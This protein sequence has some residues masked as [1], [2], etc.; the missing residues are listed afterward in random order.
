MVYRTTDR[1]AF[2]SRGADYGIAWKEFG[3]E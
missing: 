1:K 2:L 3:F